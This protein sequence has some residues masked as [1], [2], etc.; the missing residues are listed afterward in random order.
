MINISVAE[1]HHF[2]AF[3]AQTPFYGFPV[4]VFSETF[5]NLYIKCG[6]DSSNENYAT[7]WATLISVIIEVFRSPTI[8]VL[9]KYS[10]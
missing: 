6:S 4:P 7:P 9:L 5:K 1:S 2:D 8:I 3:P 10:I